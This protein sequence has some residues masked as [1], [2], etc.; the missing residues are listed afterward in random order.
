MKTI[1]RYPASVRDIAVVVDKSV[2]LS[3]IQAAIQR[4]PLVERAIFFDAYEGKGIPTT[5]SSL[6]YRLYFQSYDKTLSSTEVNEALKKVVQ[7]LIELFGAS[8][9]GEA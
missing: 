4:Q 2:P 3:E 1:S 6:G 8:L 7:T 9:R 5:K